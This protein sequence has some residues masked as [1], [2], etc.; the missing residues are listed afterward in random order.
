MKIIIIILFFITTSTK[1]LNL[2][3]MDLEL[4]ENKFYIIKNI[5]SNLDFSINNQ[6]KINLMPQK[7]MYLIKK[8]LKNNQI[9]FNCNTL[10]NYIENKKYETFFCEKKVAHK[11]MNEIKLNINF[12]KYNI[13]IKE[14]EIFYK[15][16]KYYYFNFWT[17]Y[18]VT[19]L[20]LSNILFEESLKKDNY[21]NLYIRKLGN[22]ENV[23][24]D[25][26]TYKNDSNKNQKYMNNKKSGIGWLGICLI[27]FL[28]IVVIY[29]LFILF[30]YYRRKKYQNPSFYY[31]I[32]EEMFD[33]I[34]PIE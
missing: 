11:D 7:Y 26:I 29:V 6:T 31:K 8:I 28:S 32:T 34:T 2:I 19:D 15:K 1:S 21:N 12:G 20:V 4:D 9:I 30:R 5:D 22:L 3:M 10:N 24:N 14:R 16:G 23:N 27:I 17:N 18:N 33:D 13:S 25:N